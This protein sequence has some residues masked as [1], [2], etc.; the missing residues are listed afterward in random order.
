MYGGETQYDQRF[1][2]EAPSRF[3]HMSKS[4]FVAYGRTFELPA[5]HD[6]ASAELV[7]SEERDPEER[8]VQLEN[9]Q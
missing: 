9:R 6:A 8:L 5:G 4:K 1:L 7:I 3:V 2:E